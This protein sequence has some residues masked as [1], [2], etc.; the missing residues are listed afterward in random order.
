MK[1][2]ESLK[3]LP[4]ATIALLTIAT[5][6]GCYRDDPTTDLSTPVDDG[7]K[8][9]LRVKY[10]NGGLRDE[11]ITNVCND[12]CELYKDYSFEEGKVGVTIIPEFIKSNAQV[13]SIKNNPNDVFWAEDTDYFTCVSTGQV[14]DISN[15]LNE[16][17]AVGPSKAEEKTILDKFTDSSKRYF[18]VKDDGGKDHYYAIP[19]YENSCFLN[20]NIDLFD[21]KC[22]YFAKDKTADGMSEGQ[23]N[24]NDVDD[25]F[26]TSPNDERSTGPDGIAGTFDDGLPA[27][28]A[29]F[30]ALITFMKR[31]SV[32]PFIWKGNFPD[33]LAS[34]G[35]TAW[36]GSSGADTLEAC[37]SLGGNLS[38]LIEWNN[39]SIVYQDDGTPKHLNATAITPDNG[40]LLHQSQGL[41]DSLKLAKIMIS[42]DGK[43]KNYYKNS[44][45]QSFDHL[46]AQRYFLNGYAQGIV[47]QPIG[48]LVDGTWWNSE[49]NGYYQSETDRLSRHMGI[50]PVPHPTRTQVGQPNV[51]VSDRQSMIFVRSTIAEKTI[52]VAKAFV[53]Y[54]N[55]D[56]AMNTFS[57][58]TDMLRLMNY[59]VTD[60]T[61]KSM[62][63]YGR[64]VYAFSKNENTKHINWVPMSDIAKKNASLLSY[65]TWGYSFS[66]SSGDNN[67]YTYF[68]TH[69]NVSAEDHFDAINQYFHTNWSYLLTK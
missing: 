3:T 43:D 50:M 12:F 55:S 6:G 61:L 2:K 48:I 20:Y 63:P 58:Y 16:K 21:Q 68:A 25:L 26:V 32:T 9:V 30:H 18:A 5:L 11:W 41:L 27:T 53:Q 28:Y 29:D 36:G 1:Q 42:N 44:M 17:V 38:D 24:S 22:F 64:A 39:G 37:L 45:S 54:L 69:M 47:E 49:A 15:W 51:I 19:A 56:V 23:L 7:T 60:E 34:F 62:S 66:S 46:T 59:E 33:D 10:L 35:L 8:S 40:Y 31:S 52:P 57:R 67:P 13:S 4:Y 14:Y 65:R